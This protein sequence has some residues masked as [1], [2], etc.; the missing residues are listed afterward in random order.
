MS[1]FRAT[2]TNNNNNRKIT[3]NI[4]IEPIAVIHIQRDEQSEQPTVHSNVVNIVHYKP[5]IGKK[6]SKQKTVAGD[7][8]VG[9]DDTAATHGAV[10]ESMLLRLL[11]L[12]WKM[13]MYVLH[14]VVVVMLM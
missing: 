8:Y 4:T 14:V 6:M 12:M 7:T 1:C 9:D 2:R 11:P 13:V 10:N 5:E 3:R